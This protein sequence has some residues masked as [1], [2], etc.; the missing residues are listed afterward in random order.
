M[1]TYYVV[2]LRTAIAPENLAEA[3]AADALYLNARGRPA[4]EAR[5]AW[6]ESENLARAL[7][8]ACQQPLALR[9]GEVS[10]SLRKVD[11]PAADAAR[12]AVDSDATRAWL[13]SQQTL[14]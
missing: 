5:A 11:D 4:N 3:H 8:G 14:A 9:H 13:E 10:M 1:S 6:L 12:V 2:H 7:L